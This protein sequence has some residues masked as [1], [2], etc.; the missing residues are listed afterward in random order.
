LEPPTFN[1]LKGIDYT[2]W[3]L[4][5]DGDYRSS[6]QLE[7]ALSE[8]E[9]QG[10]ELDWT[11]LVWGGDLIFPDRTV[12]TRRLRGTKWNTVHDSAGTAV[13]SADNP[14]VLILNKYRVL[15]TRFRKGMVIVVPDGSINDPTVA[16]REY[17]SVHD[18]LLACGIRPLA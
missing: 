7:V 6:N 16:Q 18:Y 15:L 11:G 9:L 10:L 14:R 2:K 4:E 1:F 13:A 8:F 12:V 5:A 3:F 17:D